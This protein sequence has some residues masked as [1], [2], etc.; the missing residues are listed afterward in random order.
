M[1]EAKYQMRTRL[2]VALRRT[3]THL[4]GAGFAAKEAERARKPREPKRISLNTSICGIYKNSNLQALVAG[5]L[6]PSMSTAHRPLLSTR[7]ERQKLVGQTL[8]ANSE[9]DG[10]SFDVPSRV[11]AFLALHGAGSL[12][13]GCIWSC[14]PRC[15][16]YRYSIKML[17]YNSSLWCSR[18]LLYFC[19]LLLTNSVLATTQCLH[20]SNRLDIRL[21]T[22]LDILVAMERL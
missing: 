11:K 14:I 3:A 17:A 5:T 12:E 7:Y 19:N 16:A 13:S 8:S 1:R 4:S 2:F 22:A 6:K 9:M 20:C 21:T 10:I 18:T 15:A